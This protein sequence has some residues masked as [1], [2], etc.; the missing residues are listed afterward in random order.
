MT[1]VKIRVKG[2]RM[3]M[4][5]QGRWYMRR[6]SRWLVALICACA[7]LTDLSCTRSSQPPHR[8]FAAPEDAVRALIDAVKAG[9]TDQF[10]SIFGPDVDQVVDNSDPDGARRRR[11]VFTAAAGERWQLVD[12]GA[13]KALVVGN[14]AWP[15]P[16][17]LVNDANGWRFDTSAGVEEVLARRIG[18]NELAAIRICRTYVTAQWLYA[19]RGH[20]GQPAGL[21]AQVFRS[22]SGQHNG[23][24]WAAGRGEK[25]SPLGDLV[26]YAAAEGRRLDQ[27]GQP[28]SPFHGYYFRILTAQGPAASGG[29]RDYV[30]NG[31]MSGGFALI[32]WP[33][34][35]DSTGVMTFVVNQDGAIRQKD[36]GPETDAA[37]KAMA[38]YN[39]DGSW[40][41]VQ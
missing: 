9:D 35:Y 24:Y 4:T 5:N 34:K 20:D 11:E 41:D 10:R 26:A 22:D 19:E 25:R 31:K 30:V 36:L 13:G 16:V 27:N 17:P 2:T 37:V 32:A 1:A 7:P 33:A 23:L 8:S 15:F 18:R 29:A 6:V 39:P 40:D 12:Q 38:L 3:A 14:E 28:P 21:Y